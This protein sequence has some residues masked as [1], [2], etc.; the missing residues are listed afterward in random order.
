[1]NTAIIIPARYGSSRLPGKP[2][3]MIAGQPML[4][5]VVD[6]ARASAQHAADIH[7]YVTTDD[8]RITA[9]CD[10]L[11]VACLMTLPE[12]ESGTDRVA[13]AV[14]QL[15]AVP[16]FI[17]NLQGDAP[18][19]PPHILQSLIASYQ[20]TPCD[21]VTPVV[22]LDWQTLDALR[23]HKQSTPF[24]GTC[25]AFHPDTKEA[26]WFSKNI[27]PAIRGEE[28]QRET[29]PISPVYRHIGLYGYSHKTLMRFP[30]LPQGHYE[31][32]EGLEQLRLLEHGYMIR[33]VPVTYGERASMS[34][35][36]SPKD[37][38]RAEALI[39][40]YGELLP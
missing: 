20:K 39:T 13:Q 16:D 5:R 33:C 37:I 15:D 8:A 6:I 32:L 35:V 21:V 26:F 31:Q 23:Q 14:E 36:D 24:S 25:A 1:M 38:A 4:K 29:T 27:I 28:A 18:L 7:V 10:E 40:Q 9:L 3:A 19:T 34:G 2:L 12:C 30:T 22:Q 11:H 17:I